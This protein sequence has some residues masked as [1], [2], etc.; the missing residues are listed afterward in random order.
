MLV[1]VGVFRR[2]SLSLIPLGVFNASLKAYLGWWQE[3][4]EMDESRERIL[5]KNNFLPSFILSSERA[6]SSGINGVGKPVG[7]V[8]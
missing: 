6:L 3:P 2:T 1:K 8:K 7:M 5:S 4:Q